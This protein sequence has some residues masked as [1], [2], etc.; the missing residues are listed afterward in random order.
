MT[1]TP[2]QEIKPDRIAEL[3]KMATDFQGSL[4]DLVHYDDVQLAMLDK[5]KELSLTWLE[6]RI[7]SKEVHDQRQ[8][9]ISTT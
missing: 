5:A 4:K 9:A 6:T 8:A 3:K 1:N 7:F 2:E